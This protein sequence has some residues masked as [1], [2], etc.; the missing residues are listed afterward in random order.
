MASSVSL[1]VK[2]ERRVVACIRDLIAD[3]RISTFCI[4]YPKYVITERVVVCMRGVANY[5]IADSRIFV[6]PILNMSS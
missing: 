3:S 4:P 6:F 1:K 2:G 5:L